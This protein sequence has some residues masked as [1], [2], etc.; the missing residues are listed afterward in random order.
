MAPGLQRPRVTEIQARMD[1]NGCVQRIKKTLNNIDGINDL[2][3]DLHQQKITIIGWADP[4]YIIK[5][6]RR[7]KRNATICSPNIEPTQSPSQPPEQAPDAT[8]KQQ[9]NGP[10]E[11]LQVEPRKE[12]P[13]PTPPPEQ[14]PEA[15]A[16]P[17]L[18]EDS[19]SQQSRSRPESEDE[20]EV[21]E[22][23]QHPPNYGSR[24]A[25]CHECVGQ[26][27]RYHSEVF[28]QEQTTPIYV[29]HCYNTYQPSPY[30]TE[31]EYVSSSKLTHYSRTEHYSAEYL[32][33]NESFTSM[34]SDE[35]PN[36][37]TIV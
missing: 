18:T 3:F 11:K 12:Q 29:T 30:V 2:Y 7:T 27:D 14:P 34:F 4:E 21:H 5:A 10:P 31:Y 24:F 6:I 1:C 20:E 22:I 9:E 26:E 35:N 16:L 36:S 23:Y 32:N 15:T 17:K 25:S 37:C 28:L 19:S 13:Q 8:P 33:G